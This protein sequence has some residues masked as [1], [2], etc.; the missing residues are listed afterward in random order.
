MKTK[1]IHIVI[2]AALAGEIDKLAGRRGRSG[3]LAKAARKELKRLRLKTL[4]KA[5]GSWKI[6]NHPELKNGAARWV[7]SLRRE[8]EYRMR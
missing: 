4:E 5:A 7:Q 3:F 1:R 2:P 6:K 8:D